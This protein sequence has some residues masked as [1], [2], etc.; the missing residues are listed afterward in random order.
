[1]GAKLQQLLPA[2]KAT[3]RIFLG[4]AWKMLSDTVSASGENAK[5]Q[6]K[7]YWLHSLY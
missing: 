3:R 5:L 4:A 1:M 6:K 7:K 2:W